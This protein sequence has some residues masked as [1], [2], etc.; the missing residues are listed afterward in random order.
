MSKMN[1]AL[2]S[3]GFSDEEAALFAM[4]WEKALDAILS[5]DTY[6]NAIRSSTS[7]YRA[8]EEAVE[9]VR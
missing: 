1:E 6:Y 8:L 5:D 3:A 4:G 7:A 2:E 9:Y